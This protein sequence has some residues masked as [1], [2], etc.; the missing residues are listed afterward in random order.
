MTTTASTPA[1]TT[2]AND[3]MV[4][5]ITIEKPQ[6][7]WKYGYLVWWGCAPTHQ[8]LVIAA[9]MCVVMQ[10]LLAVEKC[11]ILMIDTQQSN[12]AALGFF[13]KLGLGHDEQHVYL[14]NVPMNGGGEDAD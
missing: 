9:Q 5:G 12:Q 8:G 3:E 13:R 1:T 6:S 7:S 14:S 11:R 4:I 10:E 2:I